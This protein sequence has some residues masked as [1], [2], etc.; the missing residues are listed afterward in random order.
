VGGNNDQHNARVDHTFSD[1]H[2]A[3]LRYTYWSNLNLPIDPYRTQTCVDRCTETFNTNS[4]VFA[5]TYSFT[6]T[7]IF[8]LRLSFLRFSYDRT[9]LT[10]GYDLTQLG[11]PAALNNQVIVRVSPQPQVTGYNGVFSTSGSGSTIFARNDVYSL[12]P[13]MIKI[14][15]KHTIK[16]GGEFR[17]NT[18]NYYQQN[19]PS[20][21]FTFDRLMTALNPF[22]A[23]NTGDGFASFLLGY[24]N[25]GG[26]TNNAF[27]A[28]QQLYRAMHLGRSVSALEERHAE[29]RPPFRADGAVVGAFRPAHHPAAR[30]EERVV[31][32]AEPDGQDRA[33]EYA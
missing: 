12:A 7:L 32:G 24:A 22:A 8:D 23:G 25:G 3:F 16:F 2:R 30:P 4:A 27:V 31:G 14:W 33:R 9:S 6:P 29:P 19:N 17:R 28:G 1:K 13:T 5:D 26:V 18:H 10:A 21:N 15:G 20:G 11:W